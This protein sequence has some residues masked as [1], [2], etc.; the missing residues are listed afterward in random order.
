MIAAGM[1][2]DECPFVGSLRNAKRFPGCS[3]CI[4]EKDKAKFLEAPYKATTFARFCVDP[5]IRDADAVMIDESTNLFNALRDTAAVV[6]T[7]EMQKIL[8]EKGA[9]AA[10]STE[11]YN[12]KKQLEEL[13]EDMEN[14]GKPLQVYM[15]VREWGI[16]EY[17]RR[18]EQE[19]RFELLDILKDVPRV[20]ELMQRRYEN[21]LAQ[22]RAMRNKYNKLIIRC[23]GCENALAAVRAGV[24]YVIVEEPSPTPSDPDRTLQKL[25]LLDVHMPFK[26]MVNGHRVVVLASGTPITPLLVDEDSYVRVRA[27]HPIPVERRR[28]YYRPLGLMSVDYKQETIPKIAD[29]L[30]NLFKAQNEHIL[31][32][33][34]SYDVAN[35]IYKLLSG[36]TDRVVCQAPRTRNEDLEKWMHGEPAVFLSVHMEQGL[37]LAGPKFR[38]NVIAKIN[39]PNLGDMWIRDR[40]DYDRERYGFDR[41]YRTM[42]A[43]NTVQ[44]CGRTT[45]SPDDY[46]ETYILDESFGSFYRQFKFLF[47]DWFS[48]ALVWPRPKSLYT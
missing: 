21:H 16:D 3:E 14:L 41:W 8:K 38:W 34:V 35:S 45:R 13:E 2:A 18:L 33:C 32:H 11:V 9:D 5:Q 26:T 47:P 30:Y 37:D 7:K 19:Q 28:V 25:K 17:E 42:T 22:Y 36:K 46:S 27:P 48:E 29:W 40:N 1:T 20:Q 10:L 23:N 4:Y 31:V 44:A 12:L 24:R 15:G 39:F 43:I 6:V